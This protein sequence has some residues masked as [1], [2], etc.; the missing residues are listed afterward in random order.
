MTTFDAVIV[1]G[2]CAGLSAAVRMTRLG[3]RVLLLEARSRLGGRAVSLEDRETGEPV[4]NGQHVLAGCYRDTLSFL[5]DI[6]ADGH[7]RRQSHLAVTMIDRAGI[8]SRLDCS[9]LPAPLHLLAGIF[10]WS[11]LAWADRWSILR[12]AEP[13]RNARGRLQGGTRLAASEGETVEQW[14]VRNGQTDRLREMFWHPL[15]LAALNQPAGVASAAAF[16]RVLGEM[17]TSDPADATIVMP[18]RPLTEMYAEPARAH[19]ERGG[20]T[21]RTG[22]PA[23]IHIEDGRAGLVTSGTDAWRASAVVCA[24]PWFALGET[25]DGDVAPLA[26]ILHGARSME[27]S[28]IVTV[29][30]WFDRPVFDQPFVGLPGR[31]MQW[32]FDKRSIAGGRLSHVSLV[33]SGAA[34]VLGCANNALIALAHE[35]LRDALPAARAASLTHASVIREPRATFSLAPGQPTRPATVTPVEGLFLAGDWTDTG[36]PATIESAVRSGHLAAEASRQH[37]HP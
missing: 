33:S 1:G 14:L 17:F 34:D 36:L 30:L 20:G 12:M 29:N 16:A 8:A 35:E 11:A 21:V 13:L 5:H 4:D 24:V 23:R 6:G 7:V 32:A 10:D 15:A 3:A 26:P 18:T 28:P 22:A 2:G 25:V 37:T 27:A 31:V 9:G 19:I